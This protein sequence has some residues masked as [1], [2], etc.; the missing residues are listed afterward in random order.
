MNIRTGDDFSTDSSWRGN[1]PSSTQTA[2]DCRRRIA[3]RAAWRAASGLPTPTASGRKIACRWAVPL[4]LPRSLATRGLKL[5]LT[6]F[7]QYQRHRNQR[8]GIGSRPR[9]RAI[10][11]CGH[12]RGPARFEGR[13]CANDVSIPFGLELDQARAFVALVGR[14]QPEVELRSAPVFRVAPAFVLLQAARV[15][16]AGVRLEP[17]TAR[18]STGVRVEVEA[19]QC[20]PRFGVLSSPYQWPTSVGPPVRG[21]DHGYTSA[22]EASHAAISSV[23]SA[24]AARR[25]QRLGPPPGFDPA[26]RRS[27][28]TL[29]V[30]GRP[31]PARRTA[32]SSP[33]PS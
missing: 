8:V 15:A 29:A 23:I 6:A 18:A 25:D 4:S 32:S 31:T 26:P 2:P 24:I 22:S 30:R 33:S 3:L 16:Q 20:F 9:D 17:L 21:S 28:F 12:R 1:E 19:T 13:G 5:P 14:V 11:R 27:I 10:S 7:A